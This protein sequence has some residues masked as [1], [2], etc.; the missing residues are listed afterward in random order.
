MS[1]QRRFWMRW[2][3]RTGYPVGVIYWLLA[4]PS[5]RSILVCAIASAIGLL[6]R[7][8]AAGH[9]RKDETLATTGPYARTRNPLYLGSAFIAA[10]FIEAGRSWWAGMLVT[11]YFAIFYSA[12]MRNEADDLRKRFGATFDEYA[13]RVPMFFPAILRTGVRATAGELAPQKFS[14]ELFRRNRE[15]RAVIGTVAGLSLL[16]LRMWI[17]GRLGH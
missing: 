15:S 10:G 14:W 6:I 8:S 1:E 7:G 17:R 16:C 13:A 4:A 11:T 3:V 2:R 5:W 9:L 12:V